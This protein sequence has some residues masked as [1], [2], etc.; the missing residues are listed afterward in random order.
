MRPI[1]LDFAH[2]V[3]VHEVPIMN[4]CLFVLQSGMGGRISLSTV[5]GGWCM[6]KRLNG[7]RCSLGSILV[8]AQGPYWMVVHIGATWQI[9]LNDLCASLCSCDVCRVTVDVTVTLAVQVDLEM[10]V[11]VVVVEG[12]DDPANRELRYAHSPLLPIDF[13]S[14]PLCL[15]SDFVDL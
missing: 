9:Q 5:M 10:T 4:V 13:Y 7:L 1:A 14:L 11:T 2:I 6:Q 3:F 15:S 8:R 12:R